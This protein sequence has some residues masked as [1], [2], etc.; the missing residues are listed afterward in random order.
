MKFITK[1]ELDRIGSTTN[2]E[3]LLNEILTRVHNAAVEYTLRKLPE[4]VDKMVVNATAHQAMQKDFFSRNEEFIKH[5]NIVAQVIQD[6]E[7]LNSNMNYT[8]ILK[9]AEPIIKEKILAL[10]DIEKLPLDLPAA[11]NLDGNGVI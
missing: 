6:I 8:D 9:K 2:G 1:E 5:R 11:V 7:S 4:I 3:E 10:K